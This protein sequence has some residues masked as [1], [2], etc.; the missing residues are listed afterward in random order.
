[1]AFA[2]GS[3][4]VVAA[5]ETGGQVYFE[6][7]SRAGATPVS[8]PG[9]LGGLATLRCPGKPIGETHNQTGVSARS[10]AATAATPEGFVVV[11]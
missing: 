8:A 4:S 1:M 7:L 9:E 3:A 11:Y 5:W 6:D 2:E 10:F